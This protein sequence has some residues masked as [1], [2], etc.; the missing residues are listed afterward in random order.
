MNLFFHE[1]IETNLESLPVLQIMHSE[2]HNGREFN[3]TQTIHRNIYTEFDQKLSRHLSATRGDGFP[4]FTVKVEIIEAL[5]KGKVNHLA[6]VFHESV[7]HALREIAERAIERVGPVE[8]KLRRS[9]SNDEEH[10]SVCHKRKIATGDI[11][12]L[13]TALGIC[14]ALGDLD[15][16]EISGD[17]DVIVASPPGKLNSVILHLQNG[18]VSVPSSAS[19]GEPPFQWPVYAFTEHASTNLSAQSYLA[20]VGQSIV[21]EKEAAIL[22][23]RS[24]A[25]RRIVNFQT[26]LAGRP[27]D[28]HWLKGA[29]GLV[30][31]LKAGLGDDL[32]GVS[33]DAQGIALDLSA[34]TAS[35]ED[36]GA[37]SDLAP[38]R[39]RPLVLHE[40][41][42]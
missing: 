6:S 11:D 31:R 40:Q 39:Q 14:R 17:F 22:A 27:L 36:T 32:N 28:G 25:E 15:F 24:A 38:S 18:T 30:A 7:P 33:E 1:F 13:G 4:A 37:S 5:S 20:S 19:G 34:A 35:I 3:L 26:A 12:M 41:A 10:P 9:I 16:L 23:F 21:V 42:P 8:L 29:K 2:R